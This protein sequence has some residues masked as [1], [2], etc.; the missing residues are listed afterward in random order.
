MTEAVMDLGNFS[1]S[2]AVRDLAASRAFYEALGFE[3]TQRLASGAFLVSAREEAVA[4]MEADGVLA[5]VTVDLAPA[6][7]ARPLDGARSELVLGAVM[8]ARRKAMG[9][10][11]DGSGVILGDFDS[12]VDVYH[13]AFFRAGS[14]AIWLDAD[15]DGVLTPGVDGFDWD[16]NGSLD[17]TEILRLLDGRASRIFGEEDERRYGTEDLGYNPAWDYLYLDQITD[18]RRNVGPDVPG[19]DGLAA[20]G[21]PVFV[22][23]DVNGDGVITFPEKIVPLDG[24][25]FLAI[26]DGNVFRRGEN[27]AQYMPQGPFRD[28]SHATSMMGASAGGQPGYSRWLG[29]APNAELVLSSY[30]SIAGPSLT[31]GMQWLADEGADV[32]NT[33][34]GY[35]GL[36]PSDGSTE[37]E[38][39]MDALVMEGRILV[40]PAGNLGSSQKHANAVINGQNGAA[41]HNEVVAQSSPNYVAMSVTWREGN[42]GMT[43]SFSTSD[44]DVIDLGV[45]TPGGNLPSGRQYSVVSGTTIKGAGYLLLSLGGG[46]NLPASGNDLTLQNDGNVPANAALFIIDDV[47]TWGGGSG[48]ADF[49][50]EGCMNPPSLSVETISLGAY[51]LHSGP[52]YAPYP[53]AHGQLRAFSGRGPDLWGNPGIDIASPD[54]PV[55]ARA[56]AWPLG[57]PEGLYTSYTETGG[58]SGAGAI[59]VGVAALYRQLHPE[60]SG[61][62]LRDLILE[63]ALTDSDVTS[64]TPAQWGAGRLALPQML[65]P[66]GPPSVS[67]VEPAAIPPDVASD[68]TAAVT[69]DA[70]LT[71]AKSRWDF[72]Y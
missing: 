34:L 67:G 45:D 53:E 35:W 19:A 39:L 21:E 68:I 14:P 16:G 70:D 54:N 1:V 58:T 43:G 28:P 44:G 2:L 24:S 64:G 29:M 20:L 31:A 69:D 41:Y 10:E 17:E 38:L 22:A 40:S 30:E 46:P 15:G 12:Q 42:L 23:D 3:V 55:T 25:K 6:I 33:E 8:A 27:L 51:A 63:N 9:D 61:P 60:L 11:L 48:F 71:D 4:K 32:I 7:V 57:V 66:G 50:V 52:D 56:E 59:T 62:A 72:D 18:G 5:S 36:V 37:L 49:D 13:P 26:R 65:A 47:S